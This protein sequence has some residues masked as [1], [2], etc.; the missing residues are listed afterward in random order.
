MGNLIYHHIHFSANDT[1]FKN[2]N[3]FLSSTTECLSKAHP[4][5][6]VDISSKKQTYGNTCTY[7]LRI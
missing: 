5:F 1:K 2:F 6:K 3:L 4:A 7:I